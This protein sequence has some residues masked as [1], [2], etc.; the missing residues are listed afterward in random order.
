MRIK[1][2]FDFY[3][4]P[5]HG[6]VKVPVHIIKKLKIA[7]AISNHSYYNKGHV[8]LEEDC[9]LN[10]LMENHPEPKNIRFRERHTDKS[11]R[12]RNYESFDFKKFVNNL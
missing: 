11:S 4:D 2:V 6:W 9:D 3:S 10:L 1:T 5:G 8:F 12:I 7:E